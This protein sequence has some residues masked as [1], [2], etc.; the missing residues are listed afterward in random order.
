MRRRGFT[1]VELLVAVGI[2]ALLLTMLL[3]AMQG[4]RKQARLILCLSNLRQ[5][6]IAAQT[7]ALNYNDHY[8]FAQ[9]KVLTPTER[10]TACW[11]FTTI[12]NRA[13][14]EVR[15]EAGLL[16]QGEAIPEE[17]QQCPSFDGAS[18]TANDPYTGYNYNYSY[19][20]GTA[21][22]KTVGA[23]TSRT[24]TGS[25]RSG[26]VRR[27]YQ[28]AL[29]GDG[30][31]AD[32]ANKFMRSPFPGTF[33]DGVGGRSAGTQGYRHQGKTNVVYCDGHASRQ[34]KRYTIS[35]EDV[36]ADIAK[37]TGFLS[38]DNTAYA[39]EDVARYS[40]DLLEDLWEEDD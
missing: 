20:G 18:N 3:P 9:V 32:G 33:D 15:L 25:A 29:F 4:A 38:P 34:G 35:E 12:K 22:I 28:T 10:I 6:A 31:W 7:Y 30:Q 17:I 11:D 5:F 39:L 13:S 21:S 36:M 14:G 24:V 2:I 37:G 23:V 1:L 27:P 40:G 8:P 26:D 19:I 16:W